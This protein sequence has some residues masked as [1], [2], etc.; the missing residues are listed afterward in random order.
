[1][2]DDYFSPMNTPALN[3][4]NYDSVTT[5]YIPKDEDRICRFYAAKGSC[6]KGA[7]NFYYKSSCAIIFF[8][9][10]VKC[11]KLHSHPRKHV[12]TEDLI[13]VYVDVPSLPSLV[14]GSLIH[15]QVTCVINAFRFYAILPHGTRNLENIFAADDDSETL[16]SMQVI[17]QFVKLVFFNQ[18]ILSCLNYL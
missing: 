15:I 8:L 16:E 9:L 5:G 1:M 7:T 12:F 10:G 11:D 17:V 18:I 13:E 14:S 2:C 3:T 6:F 4:E